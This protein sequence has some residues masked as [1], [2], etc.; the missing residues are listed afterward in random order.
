MDAIS[1]AAVGIVSW[2]G[3][4]LR[5]DWFRLGGFLL[6]DLCLEV[7]GLFDGVFENTAAH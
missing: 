2:V 4:G 6:E 3:G 1:T 7:D 5:W